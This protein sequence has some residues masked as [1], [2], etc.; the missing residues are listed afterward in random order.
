MQRA[1]ISAAR[2]KAANRIAGAA[3]LDMAGANLTAELNDAILDQNAE[4]DMNALL[5]LTNATSK[6]TFKSPDKSVTYSREYF[7]SNP[8]VL[9]ALEEKSDKPEPVKPF[10]SY[11][12][13]DG[14]A[15]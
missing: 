1:R 4:R 13:K 12:D 14:D 11:Y 9:A 3:L 6:V 2:S 8:S 5:D 10:R 7:V 15:R